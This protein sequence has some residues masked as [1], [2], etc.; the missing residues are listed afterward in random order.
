MVK[1][2]CVGYRRQRLAS[3][4]PSPKA[5]ATAMIGFSAIVVRASSNPWSAMPPTLSAKIS[6][7]CCSDFI[8]AL[9]RPTLC[10]RPHWQVRQDLLAI[11]SRKARR[12]IAQPRPLAGAKSTNVGDSKEQVG[13]DP[14]A[15][16]SETCRR[17]NFE[18]PRCRHLKRLHLPHLQPECLESPLPAR[19]CG[20]PGT[21][22]LS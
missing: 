1:T 19:I 7:R 5:T 14:M 16:P 17:P 21:A 2:N 3:T 12:H 18:E 20:S 22:P 11:R 4:I 9:L 6:N 13:Q 15:R 8:V 10:P